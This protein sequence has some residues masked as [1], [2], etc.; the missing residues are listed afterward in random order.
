MTDHILLTLIS[1]VPP[2]SPYNKE[3][4]SLNSAAAFLEPDWDSFTDY[5]TYLDESQALSNLMLTESSM[6]LL[7]IKAY[8]LTK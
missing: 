8:D 5:V 6:L 4:F 2:A 3:E 7:D 1:V